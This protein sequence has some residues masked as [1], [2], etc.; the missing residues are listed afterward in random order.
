MRL[1]RRIWSWYKRAKPSHRRIIGISA[2]LFLYAGPRHWLP[3]HPFGIIL[4]SLITGSLIFFVNQKHQ[5]R[6]LW[7]SGRGLVVLGLSMLLAIVIPIPSPFPEPST[8]AIPFVIPPA[9]ISPEAIRPLQGFRPLPGTEWITRDPIRNAAT[10]IYVATLSLTLSLLLLDVLWRTRRVE[11]CPESSASPVWMIP[12]YALPC[13][14]IWLIYLLAFYPAILPVDPLYQW[15]QV[16]SGRFDN[17]HPAAH[18][19]SMALIYRLW[20]SPAAIALVQ[21]G[22]LGIVIGI[23]VRALERWRVPPASRW[24][25]IVLSA[26]APAH[27]MMSVTLWKDVPYAIGMLGLTG[28]LLHMTRDFHE[29]RAPSRSTWAGLVV[30]SLAV[31]LYRHNGLPVALMIPLVIAL[32]WPHQR[33]HILLRIG[34]PVIFLYAAVQAAELYLLSIPPVPRW[35][36]LQVPAHHVAAMIYAETPLTPA[37]QAFVNQ[38]QPIDLWRAAYTCQFVDPVVNNNRLNKSL[39]DAHAGEFFALWLRL[40][41]RN[42]LALIRHYLCSTEFLWRITQPPDAYV[43]AFELGT[44]SNDLGLA[45]RSLLPALDKGLWLLLRETLRPAWIWLFWRPALSLYLLLWTASLLVRRY[46]FRI[47]GTVIAPPVIHTLVWFPL[48][49]APDFRFQYPVY[50]IALCLLPMLWSGDAP[51]DVTGPSQLPFPQKAL[52]LSRSESG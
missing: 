17:V 34:L 8:R 35:F 4:I 32:L 38:I 43:Y 36:A 45:S 47:A 10:A 23:I 31:A 46:G 19:L 5:D 1:H 3:L 18:T 2:W 15:R 29:R 22:A 42:P 20:P 25:V 51:T 24:L 27:G 33:L 40:I 26:I 6:L 30:S 9:G 11:A 39:L 13:W 16:L 50:G 37:E 52:L 48:L 14:F 12:I 28:G 21:I 44:P 49:T 7:M 41:V